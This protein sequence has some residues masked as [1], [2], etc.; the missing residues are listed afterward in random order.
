MPYSGSVKSIDDE[1][2]ISTRKSQKW[3]DFF[4]MIADLVSTRSTCLS[5]HAGAVV[6]RDKQIISTGYNG[7]SRGVENCIER[8]VCMRREKGFKSGEGLEFCYAAHAEVNALLQAAKHGISTNDST[9]YSTTAP[10]SFCAR[11][12]INAGIVK[13][14]YMSGYPHEH[15]LDM[16]KEAGLEIFKYDEKK[17]DKQYASLNENLFKNSLEK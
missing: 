3:D 12:V 7:A 8:G 17:L 1:V 2:L 14:V 9:L 15:A 10:C 13:V 4:M 6:V 5:R 11:E 16:M